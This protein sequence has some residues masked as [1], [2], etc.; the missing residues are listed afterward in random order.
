MA[1]FER[2]FGFHAGISSTTKIFFNA[3]IYKAERDNGRFELK[4]N[5]MMEIY[6]SGSGAF[7]GREY[8][9]W[10]NH[11]KNSTFKGHE[12]NKKSSCPFLFN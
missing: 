10:F 2:K 12:E 3:L 1:V 7:L 9:D 4:L 5:N 11:I 8:D 6:I